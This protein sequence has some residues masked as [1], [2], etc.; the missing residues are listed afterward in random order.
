MAKK[1]ITF[2]GLRKKYKRFRNNILLVRHLEDSFSIFFR[3]EASGGIV[4]VFFTLLALIFANIP[5]L[6]F[7]EAVWHQAITL[8]FGDTECSFTLLNAVND[9]LMV[10]FFLVVGLEIKREM[11]VGEL[12]SLKQASLPIVAAIGGML[13][14]ALIYTLFNINSPIG[15]AGRGWGV[16]MGTD[17]AFA[18]GILAMMG[19]MV[20]L[21]LKI[22]LIA[23]SI[24]DDLGAIIVIAIF[25]PSHDIHTSMLIYAVLV[26]AFLMFCNIVRVRSMLVYL[27]GGIFLWFFVLQSGIHATIAGVLLAI[28]IPS[29]TRMNEIR[30]YVRGK[31]L[32]N[33]F[34]ESYAIQPNFAANK[35]AQEI[36]E[37]ISR[38][39]EY[40][41]PM[42]I[43]LEKGLHPLVMFV[44]M[45]LFALANAGVTF[46]AGLLTEIT[47]TVSLGI[48]F[49]LLI[50]KPLGIMTL[51]FIAVKLKI[52]RLPNKVQWNQILAVASL[53]GI[54]FTMSL[55]I[56]RLAFISDEV[57]N[58][59][60]TSIL[61][62]SVL[63]GLMGWVLCKATMPRT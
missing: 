12:S 58:I 42:S 15:E 25:Y 31:F 43:T 10:I 8:T 38:G 14:P 46:Q 35:E 53:A 55:F 30:F 33:K 4:L 16:P 39:I 17:I 18:V 29:F 32:I 59:G 61:L 2:A 26:F 60:K 6:S 19:K 57:I 52:A 44:V 54:G 11:M 3:R 5:S 28:T 21:S 62:A 1:K 40:F 45:P 56:N 27:V 9:G 48:L 50:G 63:A 24:V 47:S 49:G 41:R 36:V 37:S 22:F 51:S 34:K 7:M 23:L 20:P 13:F